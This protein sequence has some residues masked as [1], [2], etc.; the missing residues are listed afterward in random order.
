[1]SNGPLHVSDR[2]DRVAIKCELLIREIFES[3]LG[4]TD[5]FLQLLI[6]TL[7]IGN[8]AH[9]GDEIF[10]FVE[11]QIVRSYFHRENSP[12]FGFVLAFK[13]YRAPPPQILPECRKTLS[14]DSRG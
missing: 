10:P 14:R 2:D 1:M 7:A 12:V 3:A 9:E 11:V 6:G 8:V 5:A 13:G 4:G